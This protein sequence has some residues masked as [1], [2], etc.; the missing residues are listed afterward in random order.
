MWN[1][2]LIGFNSYKEKPSACVELI[3]SKMLC[4]TLYR[5]HLQ[6]LFLKLSISISPSS[7]VQKTLKSTMKSSTEQPQCQL[8]PTAGEEE[9]FKLLHVPIP[10][11]FHVKERKSPKTTLRAP[12]WCR[13]RFPHV[14]SSVWGHFPFW[15]SP[16]DP[17]CTARSLSRDSQWFQAGYQS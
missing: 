13:P 14:N 15:E 8:T 3:K 2:E 7:L 1:K 17:V 11:T 12:A 6:H 10:A 4:R 16:A 9:K 5:E